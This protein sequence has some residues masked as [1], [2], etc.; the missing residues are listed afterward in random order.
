M[1][2]KTKYDLNN[3]FVDEIVLFISAAKPI[4]I[5]KFYQHALPQIR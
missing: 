3:K 2:S 1:S 4:I 5:N